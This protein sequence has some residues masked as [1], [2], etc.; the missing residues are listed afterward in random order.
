MKQIVSDGVFAAGCEKLLE[1]IERGELH[2][3]AITRD[4]HVIARLRP[5][6]PA[7]DLLALFPAPRP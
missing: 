7:I 5:S 6:I 1:R 3:I 2:E 4:G